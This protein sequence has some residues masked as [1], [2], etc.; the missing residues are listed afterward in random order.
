MVL[1]LPIINSIAGK[2]GHSVTSRVKQN[3]VD[4]LR[5]ASFLKDYEKS[6]LEETG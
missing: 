5:V 1:K 6:N 2:N 4:D 3:L